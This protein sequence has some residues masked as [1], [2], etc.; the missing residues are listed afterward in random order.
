MKARVL[1]VVTLLLVLPA[2]AQAQ[3]VFQRPD[4]PAVDA[5]HSAEARC[6]RDVRKRWQQA[7]FDELQK[8]GLMFV[9]MGRPEIDRHPAARTAIDNKVEGSF[10]VRFSVAPDGTVYNVSAVDVTAGIEPLAKMWAET[11]GQWTFVK[12]GKAMADLEYRRIYLYASD[13]EAESQK[14]PQATL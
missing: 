13:D 4:C 10:T 3:A 5:V 1:T 8:T 14:K 2:A 12:P 6:L 9:H 11:I 7:N